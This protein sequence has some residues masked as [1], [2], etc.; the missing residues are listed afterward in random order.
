MK[1]RIIITAVAAAIML[2]GCADDQSDSSGLDSSEVRSESSVT[3][4]SLVQTESSEA[5]SSSRVESSVAESLSSQDESSESE[6]SASESSVTTTTS[7]TQ[8]TA[9]SVS[10][11]S[12]A[13]TT[14]AAVTSK[15]QATRQ[16]SAAGGISFEVYSAHTVNELITDKSMAAKN[17]Y[18]RVD[19]SKVGSFETDVVCVSG[20]VEV[21]RKLSYS[22]VDKTPPVLLY[23]GSGST[24]ILG[25]KFD[26]NDY[27]GFADNYDKK[28]VLT[29]TGNVNANAAG[30]YPLR[31]TATDSSGNK[32]TWD[33]T[34]KVAA[35]LP[36]YVDTMPI[37]PYGDFIKRTSYGSNVRFGI[38]VSAWQGNIDFKAVKN[39]GCKF[40]M[41]RIGTYYDSV[42]LDKYFSANLNNAIAAGLDVGVYF[43]TTDRTVEG[44]REH[45]RW[46]VKQLGGKKLTM[47]IAYDWEDFANFQKYGISLHDFNEVYA[48]FSDE[49]KKN[50]YKP[51]I[52]GSPL[53]LNSMWSEGNKAMDPVW[54]AHYVDK[55][56]YQG[57]YAIWQV[58]GYGRIAGINGNVDL[59]VQYMDKK[60]M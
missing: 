47:P 5:E 30:S 60:I 2:S 42:A 17:A 4:S 59:D 25:T 20:G 12:A 54:L 50:G 19:T 26:L 11:S 31:A 14:A 8:A 15:P 35:S 7:G 45:A 43:F 55:T 21:T 51:M 6:T 28:P 36:P 22:V 39:A 34:I 10:A 24:H 56:N 1:L 44:A 37:V 52:Y 32:T 23:S 58:R 40:V 16:V 53:T 41:I 9:A 18:A 3:D 49:I 29:Y 46:I 13:T 38:D 48:A 33:L 57:Q 27:V